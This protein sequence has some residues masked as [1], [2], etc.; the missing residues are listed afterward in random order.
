LIE[1]VVL[2][3]GKGVRLEPITHTRPK[4]LVP[5]LNETLISRHLRQ[6]KDLG[7]GRVIIVVRYMKR[8]VIEYVDRLNDDLGLDVEFVDQ[9]KELGT[10]HAVLQA[11]PY[12]KSDEVLVVYGD[13]YLDPLILPEMLKAKGNTLLAVKGKDPSKYGLLIADKDLMVKDIIEKP[14][15]EVIKRYKPLING[16]VY[17]LSKDILKLS[18]HIELSPRGEYE[19]TD[20]IKL[21][22]SKGHRI[23]ALLINEDLWSDVGYLWNVLDVNKRELMRLKDRVIRG[24]I[25]LNATIKGPVVI[26]EGTYVRSGTYIEGPVY[27]G[28][29]CSIGPNT[30]LRPYS[31]I[32]EGSKVGASVEV[33]ASLIMEHVHAS[34]LSYIGDSIVCEHANLG[35]GTI[36]AN[37]RF[38]EKD[39]KVFVKGVRISSGRKKL[40]AFIGGHVKTG[41]NVSIYPGVKIGAYSWIYPGV[42]VKK[43]VPPWTVVKSEDTYEPLKPY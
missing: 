22:V 12:L 32:L 24:D 38:D 16:G 14:P 30:Y 25:E 39:V 18:E 23:K 36:T 7:I 19:F 4:V 42:R 20:V 3:A 10:G 34:H 17:K 29:D 8:E 27:I 5:I 1:A 21:A 15:S 35:A 37:L 33:K 2:A 28:K 40:G 9:G 31:V 43:D 6:L 11:L 13:L 41:I 26:E